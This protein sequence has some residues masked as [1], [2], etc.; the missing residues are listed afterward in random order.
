MGLLPDF[1]HGGVLADQPRQ[2][3]W[4][5]SKKSLRDQFNLLPEVN[6]MKIL[7]VWCKDNRTADPFRSV[8]INEI[9]YHPSLGYDE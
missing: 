8:K 3:D 6:F 9:I 1:G 7:F 5:M 4:P 2:S